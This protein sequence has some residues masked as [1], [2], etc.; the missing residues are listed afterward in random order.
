MRTFGRFDPG[1]RS[2]PRAKAGPVA[3]LSSSSGEYSSTLMD[4]SRTGMLLRG[5]RLPP[6]GED[7]LLL[8]EDVRA[9]GQV[10]RMEDDICAVEF[11]TPI[12]AVEV[13]RLQSLAVSLE[14]RQ[15]P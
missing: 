9:W 14:G 15:G 12:A 1:G 10:V 6:E 11:D 7:V 3:V 5:A 8:T 13:Q 2:A 4:V